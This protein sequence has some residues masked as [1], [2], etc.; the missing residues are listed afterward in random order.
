MKK[1][2]LALGLWLGLTCSAEA[3]NPTCPTRPLGDSSNACASTAFVG[4]AVVGSL[5]AGVDQNVLNAQTSAYP[6]ATTDCGKTITLGGSAFYTLTIGAASGFPPTCSI[7]VANID[8][9]RGKIMAINGVTFPNNSILWPLQTFTLKNENNAWTVINPPGRWKLAG[10]VQFEVNSAG[11]N[12]NDGLATGAANA[13][14]T[15]PGAIN[16]LSTSVDAAQQFIKLHTN[17]VGVVTYTGVIAFQPIVNQNVGFNP[18]S[19]K[20][21]ILSGDTTTPTNCILTSASGATVQAIG[22]VQWNIEGFQVKNTDGSSPCILV[23]QQSWVRAGVMDFNSCNGAAGNH[24]VAENFSSYEA[25]ANYTISAG[26]SSHVFTTLMGEFIETGVTVTL[27]GTPAFAFSFATSER[28]SLQLWSGT[29]FSGS[30]TG[31][32]YTTT[33]GGGIETSGAGAT[34]LP[35]NSAGTATN[36]GW[37][38]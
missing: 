17:C 11:S 16:I 2:L 25:T 33:I 1:L 8:T 15:I 29:T 14:Q 30:A 13:F 37:Y 4:N 7:V 23:D 18:A 32:R 34:F 22:N 19:Q 26:A 38:N 20:N 9:G 35:G 12:S 27:T 5:P 6:A 24:I 31:K 10:S 3:Q 21:P 28:N 36:P